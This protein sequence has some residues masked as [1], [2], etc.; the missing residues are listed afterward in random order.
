[1]EIIW[2]VVTVLEF[3]F[4][5]KHGHLSLSLPTLCFCLHSPPSLRDRLDLFYVQPDPACDPEGQLWF[6]STPLERQILE[7]LLTRVLL[8]RDVYTDKHYPEEDVEGVD[9]GE[10]AGVE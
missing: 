1:M 4:S 2:H 6:T 9:D 7:N 8:V 10:A 5:V 3:L